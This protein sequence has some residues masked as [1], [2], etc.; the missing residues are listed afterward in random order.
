MS[1]SA[2]RPQ[3]HPGDL[4]AD[5]PAAAAEHTG[6][7]AQHLN[8]LHGPLA[9]IDL[10]GIL[11]QV[12]V[13]ATEKTNTQHESC[14]AS[15]ARGRDPYGGASRVTRREE[16]SAAAHMRAMSPRRDGSDPRLF[17]AIEAG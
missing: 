4:A 12:R 9:L 7:L 5:G 3:Q 1:L 13:L 8:D 15:A 14:H 17:A 6:V 11:G 10:V 2:G 16:R